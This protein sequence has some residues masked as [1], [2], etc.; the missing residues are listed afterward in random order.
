MSNITRAYEANREDLLN[1]IS[2][3]EH[4]RRKIDKDIA[5]R[6]AAKEALGKAIQAMK[7]LVAN[8]D[9]ELR[10]AR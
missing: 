3:L 7:Q 5:D 8:Y 2:V 6:E 1:T 4:E 9:A 10:L